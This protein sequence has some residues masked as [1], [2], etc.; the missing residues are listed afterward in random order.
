MPGEKTTKQDALGENSGLKA[1]IIQDSK[2]WNGP[3]I[4]EIWPRTS[5]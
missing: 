5:A 3:K 4:G 1:N 2:K